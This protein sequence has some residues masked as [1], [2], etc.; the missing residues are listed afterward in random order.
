MSNK[1]KLDPK[2]E[3]DAENQIRAALFDA[4]HDSHTY[5]SPDMP[6]ELL[7]QF[8][9]NVK[10]IEEA[11][12][13]DK[14]SVRELIG[15]EFGKNPFPEDDEAAELAI[16]QIDEHLRRHQIIMLRPDHLTPRGYYRFLIEELP[17][18]RIVPPKSKQQFITIDYDRVRHD[19]PQ[20][21]ID[22][23]EL[24]LIGLLSLDVPF[25]PDILASRVRLGPEVVS[26]ERGVQHVNEWRAQ[27]K[28]I[29]PLGFKPTDIQAIPDNGLF[30]LFMVAYQATDMNGN[31]EE[32]SGP[33]TSQVHFQ[34]GEFRIEGMSIP[35]F[36]F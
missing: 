20:F 25:P 6:P 16:T 15:H 32:Y 13:S 21:V 26:R 23:T 19:A 7:E 10:A 18:V 28:E 9:A 11:E 33:G 31:T 2:E 4:E 29:V 22:R 24:F 27:W 1:E 35:G 30:F 12:E 34:D 17:E 14:K 36:E 3:Q 5:V 8:L